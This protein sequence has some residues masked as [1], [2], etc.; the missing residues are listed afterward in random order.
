MSTDWIHGDYSHDS[1]TEEQ[2]ISNNICHI[3]VQE[4]KFA[5]LFYLFFFQPKH[6]TLKGR[7]DERKRG[8]T[9]GG[10][11]EGQL[12]QEKIG[13]LQAYYTKAVRGAA[14][15]NQISKLSQDNYQFL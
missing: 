3:I 4:S 11:G 6:W 1:T 12:T 13:K 9:L 2:P 10:R 7:S 8:V 14:G 15:Q 5:F